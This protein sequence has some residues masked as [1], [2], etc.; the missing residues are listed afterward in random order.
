MGCF[1]STGFISKLPIIRGDRIVCFI[2]CQ[3]KNPNGRELYYPDDLVGL[4]FL[5]FYGTYNDYGSIKDVDRTRVVELIEKYSLGLSIENVCDII[6]RMLF[7]DNLRENLEYFK[8]YKE[9]SE[10]YKSLLPLFFNNQEERP[11]LLF[12]HEEIYNKLTKTGWGEK[13]FYTRIR[14]VNR[15]EKYLSFIDQFHELW[16][17]L[18]DEKEKMTF[19]IPEVYGPVSG[20]MFYFGDNE[21]YKKLCEEVKKYQLSSLFSHTSNSFGFFDHLT[22]EETFMVLIECRDEFKKYCNLWDLYTIAPM[23]FG[24]SKTAGEQDYNMDCL[25]EM[26][27]TIL[28]K[29][30]EIKNESEE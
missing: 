29:A 26:Y 23:Y 10:K 15:V 3:S 9:K 17:K 14:G 16:K 20:S 6:E 7:G 2:G 8:E 13:S 27:E 25:I 4:F 30:R 12:E 19:I 21:E 5:P 28:E 1:N 11:V 22:I 24:F 18:E